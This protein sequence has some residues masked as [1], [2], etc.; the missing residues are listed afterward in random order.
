IHRTRLLAGELATVLDLPLF[1]ALSLR[2]PIS[3]RA[4]L[5]DG[6][7]AVDFERLY[8][9]ALEVDAAFSGEAVLLVDDVCTKGS[10]LTQAARA[11]R[12]AGAKRLVAVTAGQMILRRVVLSE[13]DIRQASAQS[14]AM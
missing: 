13:A 3:K 12:D 9:D 11:L 4:L 7:G 5:A 2:R 10:T 1:E 14:V 8:R 6:V